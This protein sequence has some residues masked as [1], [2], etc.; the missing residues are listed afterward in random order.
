MSGVLKAVGSVVSSAVSWVGDAISSVADFVVDGILSPIADF[1]GGFIDGFLE[2]PF[3]SIAKIAAAVS[4]QPWVIALVNGAATAIEGGGLG[5]VLLSTAGSYISSSLGSQFNSLIGGAGSALTN[6]IT[7]PELFISSQPTNFISDALSNTFVKEIVGSGVSGAANAII[8]GEDPVEAF[9]KGGVTAGISAGLGQ[10]QDYLGFDTLVSDISGSADSTSFGNTVLDVV[11]AGMRSFLAEGEI[12]PEAMANAV[13]RGFIT[14]DVV[15]NLAESLGVGYFE[16]PAALAY[17]TAA[18]QRVVGTALS[19]GSGQQ[20]YAALESTLDAY[21]SAKF[22]E[23]LDDFNIQEVIGKTLDVLSGNYDDVETAATNY[24]TIGLRRQGDAKEYEDKRLELQTKLDAINAEKTRIQGLPT[25]TAAQQSAYN[26]AV[27]ALNTRIS[28]WVKLRD[29]YQP[30]MN[31]LAENIKRDTDLLATAKTDLEDAYGDLYSTTDTLNTELKPL[32]DGFL[33][34]ITLT[35]D[36]VFNEDGYRDLN[37]LGEDVNVYEHFLTQ[38]QYEDVY[39]NYEQFY[40]A[41][42]VN[43]SALMNKVFTESG[44]DPDGLTSDQLRNLHYDIGEIYDRPQDVEAAINDESAVANLVDILEANVAQY[45]DNPYR[46]ATLT[47]ELRA[48]LGGLGFVFGLED[49]GALSNEAKAAL[50]A[51]DN[52]GQSIAGLAPGTTWEDVAAGRAVISYDDVGS[53]EWVDPEKEYPNQGRW[54]PEYGRVVREAD[55]VI[56]PDGSRDFTVS[57]T[58]ASGNQIDST[59]YGSSSSYTLS[60]ALY[61]LTQSNPTKSQI[62]STLSG[63]PEVQAA[64][65]QLGGVDT[66]INLLTT[67]ID[68]AESTGNSELINTVANVYKAGGGIIQ[69]FNGLV[70]LVN[71]V[72]SETQVG[73]F[74]DRLVKLGESS[75]TEEYKENVAAL[76]ELMNRPSQLD[77]D[78]PWYERAFEKMENIAGA[79]SEQ[80]TAFLTEYIGVEAVQE[81]VPLAVG[82]VATLGAKGAAMALGKTLSTRMAATTG[83]SA[84]ATSDIAES[85]GGTAAE[86][87]DRAYEV[88]IKN[89][90]SEAEAQ[91]YAMNLSVKAGTVAATL[92]AVT[93][94]SGSL[95]LEKAILGKDEVGGFLARGLDELKSRISNGGKITIREG[96]TESIEEGAATAYRESHLAQLDPTINVSGE[97]AGAALLGFLVGGPIAGGAYG[98]QQTGDAYSNVMAMFNPQVNAIVTN[99][100]NTTEGVQSAADSLSELGFTGTTQTNLLNSI[101]D[102]GYTST[103]EAQSAFISANSDYQVTQDE[104]NQFTVAGDEAETSQAVVDYIDPRYVDTQEVI[105]T[106]AEQGLTITEEQAAEYVGQQDEASTLN[107]AAQAYDPLA[108]TA[109]EAQSAFAEAGYNPTDAETSQ[110]VMEGNEAE[111]LSDIESYVDPRQVTTEEAQSFFDELG[112]TPTE[113]EVANLVGQGDENF[114]A[115]TSDEVGSYVDPRQVTEEEVRAAYAEAGLGETTQADIDRF[116]GQFDPETAD[117]D[118]GDFQSV[119]ESDIGEYLPTASSNILREYVGA[120]SIVDDPN[121]EIDE[122]RQA[123]GLFA[124]LESAQGAV[125]QLSTDFDL[126]I[127]DTQQQITDLGTDLSED[128]SGVETALGSQISGVETAL[129][130]QITDLGTDLTTDIQ[131]VAEL[132]GKPAQDVTQAD[133]DFV[134]DVIAQNQVIT[135]QQVTQYDVTGDGIV[136]INDQTLLEQAL[137]GGT[138]DLASTSQFAPTG[139]YGTVQDVQTDLTQQLDTNQQQAMDAIQQF[140]TNQE[141]AMQQNQEQTMNRLQQIEQSFITNIEDQAMRE[142]GRNFLQMALQ[143]PDAAGQQVSVKTPDPLNLGYIYDFSSIFANPSQ[144][145]LFPTP[146]AK[147]GRVDSTTDRLLQ[148]IGD[149]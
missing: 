120:P 62:S 28:N 102:A 73:Q 107:E 71:E 38:G 15:N 56:S 148:I 51:Q 96:L 132:V 18:V 114:E 26:A 76:N 17:T 11:G 20:A 97:T 119:I 118:A 133:I 149:S 147:G 55:I 29:Q 105:E 79:I 13:T 46:D 138:V 77:A 143:A 12:T 44:I 94:G 78:A 50:Y 61:A 31:L 89:G 42:D 134:A 92:T 74:A 116:I 135:E 131:S 60:D 52:R 49:E 64:G 95:A 111:I 81:L 23:V 68:L 136:D 8:Y 128:I 25:K 124:E 100:P 70:T 72:P 140:E 3:T 67:V 144:Q 90:M 88:A 142:G 1:A 98:V 63:T 113:E 24:N 33:K 41:K 146:Y 39:T 127:G 7:G 58:D 145:A 115:T 110:F 59:S 106:A 6:N 34:A 69:S 80:P 123:T 22:K 91:D 32:N 99:T 122:S 121:T 48:R 4:G 2:N 10:I 104:I 75:N 30:R 47:P 108:T 36:P 54:D 85:Y 57:T 130:S 103:Q 93:L 83:L 19:G 129:G 27:G 82:G 53:R 125:D 9:L 65:E 86:T 16:D 137:G 87:Y 40:N 37:N 21:G 66:A 141:L 112:F 84:A 43:T 139:I 45:V 14:S 5:D 117:Y 126:A 101:N 35:M 109:E